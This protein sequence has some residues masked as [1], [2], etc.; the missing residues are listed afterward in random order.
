MTDTRV[1]LSLFCET[2]VMS[3]PISL[4]KV[5]ILMLS[6]ILANLCTTLIWLCRAQ[7]Y[8][9]PGTHEHPRFQSGPPPQIFWMEPWFMYKIQVDAR[10]TF[11]PSMLVFMLKDGSQLH[12]ATYTVQICIWL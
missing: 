1:F 12:F 2:G 4:A 10:V 5:N 8:Q 9:T 6:K 11:L 7:P 3:L